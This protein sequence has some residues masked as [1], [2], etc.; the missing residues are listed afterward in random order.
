M[1]THAA[2][3]ETSP[4]L[5]RMLRALLDHG[6]LSTREIVERAHVYAVNS[7]ASELRSN[8]IAVHCRQGKD[9]DGSRIWLYSLPFPGSAA[10]ELRRAEKR[11]A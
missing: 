5:R 8:G 7:V 10:L 9:R 11:A 4:R 2:Q 6:E 1:A 3:L